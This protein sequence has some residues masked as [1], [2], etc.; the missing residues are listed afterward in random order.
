MLPSL[1]LATICYL[2]RIGACP[3]TEMLTAECPLKVAND[4]ANAVRKFLSAF[5]IYF[6]TFLQYEQTHFLRE[7]SDSLRCLCLL[8]CIKV[9]N[10]ASSHKLCLCVCVCMCEIIW[11]V[12][13]SSNT[14]KHAHEGS[15]NRSHSEANVR[16][17]KANYVAQTHLMSSVELSWVEL[18][19]AEL[20]RTRVELRF[21][22]FVELTIAFIYALLKVKTGIFVAYQTATDERHKQC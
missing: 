20:A 10:V 19:L 4:S 9:V 3:H 1:K 15:S 2:P 7:F 6:P 17:S 13:T 11:C 8:L 21:M 16:A 22:I 14:R 18:S 12:T 5:L